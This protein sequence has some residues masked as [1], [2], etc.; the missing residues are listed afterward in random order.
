MQLFS[1]FAQKGNAWRT[2]R[3]RFVRSV[4]NPDE[5]QPRS[6]QVQA[7]DG[8]VLQAFA[9]ACPQ[10]TGYVSTRGY[11]MA[12]CGTAAEG[13]GHIMVLRY[14]ADLDRHVLT[15]L[16]Y[17]DVHLRTSTLYATSDLGYA[18]AGYGN[19]VLRA[20]P[21]KGRIDPAEDVLEWPVGAW[22]AGAVVRQ[23]CQ[24]GLQRGGHHHVV[25][26]LPDG[27][28]YLYA[29]DTFTLPPLRVDLFPELRAGL[30]RTNY[31]CEGRLAV[32]LRLGSA[33]GYVARP[34]FN[35]TTLLQIDLNTALLVR[36]IPLPA[37]VAD[38]LGDMR[39][40]LPAVPEWSVA[41]MACDV[42]S[43][44]PSTPA[45]A[46][47]TT[48]DST[49]TIMTLA[50]LLAVAVVLIVGL[51]FY[52]MRSRATVRIINQEKNVFDNPNFNPALLEGNGTV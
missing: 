12:G 40:V 37:A 44:P 50:V 43:V 38:N 34:G 39:L 46:T 5:V 1:S 33:H 10:Y 36:T 8:T 19:G 49:S 3:C 2:S 6:F 28:L 20:S 11:E 42:L 51:T 9:D 26:V 16:S 29:S 35:G 7:A 48:K 18:I 14:H 45:G 32:E 27:Y 47:S 23:P 31:T 15:R 25:A 17:P 24:W 21:S 13:A 41:D 4:Y 30:A 52:A 22:P